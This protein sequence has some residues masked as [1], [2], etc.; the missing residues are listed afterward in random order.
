MDRQIGLSYTAS[1][2]INISYRISGLQAESLALTGRDGLPYPWS[3]YLYT[4]IIISNS[5]SVFFVEESLYKLWLRV[6]WPEF[7]HLKNLHPSS[8]GYHVL[9]HDNFSKEF[10]FHILLENSRVHVHLW[11]NGVQLLKYNIYQ[12]SIIYWKGFNI[13]SLHTYLSLCDLCS[14]TFLSKTLTL[15]CF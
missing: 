5:D 9:L 13:L 4:P 12:I 6:I 11:W 8:R 3:C 2:T 7:L 10:F 14:P 15:Y 1:I